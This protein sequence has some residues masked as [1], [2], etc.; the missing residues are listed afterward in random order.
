MLEAGRPS[1][2]TAQAR[3]HG[4]LEGAKA[5]CFEFCRQRLP[6]PAHTPIVA[7]V[8]SGGYLLLVAAVF[9]KYSSGAAAVLAVVAVVDYQT[10]ASVS[11]KLVFLLRLP[12]FCLLQ[13]ADRCSSVC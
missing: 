1:D 8:S 3:K 12:H 5:R 4:G 10:T 2:Q 9:L 11:S 7:P 6:E 13:W